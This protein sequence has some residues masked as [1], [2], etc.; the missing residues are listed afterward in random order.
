MGPAMGGGS[1]GGGIP[2]D[3]RRGK[4]AKKALEIQWVYPVWK[5][6]ER[7]LKPGETTVAAE[8]ERA[9]PLEKAYELACS[10]ANRNLDRTEWRD[11]FGDREYRA[12]CPGGTAPPA[13]AEGAGQRTAS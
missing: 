11:F 9:L 13:P 3:F 10:V 4:T 2:L 12:S 1:R 8:R 7:E 5:P 6:V